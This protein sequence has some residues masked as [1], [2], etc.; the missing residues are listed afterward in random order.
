MVLFYCPGSHA[1]GDPVLSPAWRWLLQLLAGAPFHFLLS[2]GDEF[3]GPPAPVDASTGVVA[4]CS[5]GLC[6][7]RSGL[8]SSIVENQPLSQT[9]EDG[10][11]T[12][13]GC[14]R[15]SQRDVVLG[16]GFLKPLRCGVQAVGCGDS[17]LGSAGNV[18]AG[19][20]DVVSPSDSAQ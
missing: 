20:G 5:Y 12:L 1:P 2:P 10:A 7:T 14:L 15:G 17:A 6:R 11:V 18:L 13:S 3:R 8:L 19:I 16:F 4:S 9:V